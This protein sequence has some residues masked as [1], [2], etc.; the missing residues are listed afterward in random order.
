MPDRCLLLTVTLSASYWNIPQVRTLVLREAALASDLFA[1]FHLS[2]NLEARALAGKLAH[3]LMTVS[4]LPIDL[5]VGVPHA[6]WRCGQVGHEKVASQW[7]GE[8]SHDL[9][10]RAGLG[11][12]QE[13]KKMLSVTER[14][15]WFS[16][17]GAAT[18]L[19]PLAGRVGSECCPQGERVSHR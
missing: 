6:E 7:L 4:L 1:K 9:K 15:L 19:A 10:L 17:V 3:F 5:A 14:L 8:V 18:P 11:L 2:W 16:W 12:D 13:G